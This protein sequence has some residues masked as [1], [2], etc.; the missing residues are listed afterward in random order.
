[1]GKKKNKK[2][3][4]EIV[5][6]QEP[7]LT[8]HDN[9]FAFCVSNVTG[10][11]GELF[12]NI[13]YIMQNAGDAGWHQPYLDVLRHHSY[14]MIF[15]SYEEKPLEISDEIALSDY[16]LNNLPTGKSILLGSTS[17]LEFKAAVGQVGTNFRMEVVYDPDP[18]QEFDKIHQVGYF[19]STFVSPDG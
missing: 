19:I 17:E 8:M 12:N 1:M 6:D 7:L 18:S 3:Q 14:D 11:P 15:F 9:S 4:S 10:I 5:I 2:K 13:D 16:A